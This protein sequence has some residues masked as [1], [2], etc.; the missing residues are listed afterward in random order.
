MRGNDQTYIV[1]YTIDYIR[2]CFGDLCKV[3]N[4]KRRSKMNYILIEDNEKGTVL[5]NPNF[6]REIAIRKLYPKSD[7]WVII[8]RDCNFAEHRIDKIF[9]SKSEAREYLRKLFDLHH[10]ALCFI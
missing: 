8:L 10:I 7:E 2:N 9:K 4:D 1:I 6:I 5:I 3:W